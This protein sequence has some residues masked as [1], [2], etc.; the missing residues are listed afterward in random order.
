M[1]GLYTYRCVCVVFIGRKHH[2][3]YT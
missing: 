3:M 2:S 1:P